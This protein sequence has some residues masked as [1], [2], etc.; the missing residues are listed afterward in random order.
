MSP[1]RRMRRLV[2][3]S[4]GRREGGFTL[5]E[6]LVVTGIVAFF[7]FALV[8][9]VP[10]ISNGAKTVRT[11]A[12]I[13]LLGTAVETYRADYGGYPPCRPGAGSAVT[14]FVKGDPA[15]DT[16]RNLHLY[17]GLPRCELVRVESSG[18]VYK[19]R[20]PRVPFRDEYLKGGGAEALTSAA[21]VVTTPAQIQAMTGDPAFRA[22]ARVLVDA[23][24]NPLYYWTYAP[25]DPAG[26]AIPAT[27]RPDLRGGFLIEST[28]RPDAGGAFTWYD[29]SAGSYDND[30]DSWKKPH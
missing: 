11:K 15:Q 2:R 12:F 25:G 19:I 9:M 13:D 28:G 14:N 30:V 7:V 22:R 8:V 10:N 3:R 16:S 20:E 4:I 1:V 23:W 24:D 18:P 21:S 27:G 29:G 6:M 5:I 26:G 17:L